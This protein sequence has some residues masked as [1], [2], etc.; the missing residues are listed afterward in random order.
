MRHWQVSRLRTNST[1]TLAR[2]SQGPLRCGWAICMLFSVLGWSGVLAAVQTVYV[3]PGGSDRNAGTAGAPFVSIQEARDYVR[4]IKADAR[5]PVEIVLEAGTYYLGETLTFGPQDSGTAESP[6][7]YRAAEPGT[8]TLSGGVKIEGDWQPYRDGIFMC[9]LDP[10]FA[11]GVDF[12]ELWVNGVRQIRARFPNGDS[13][14]PQPAGYIRTTG[15]DGW[16]HK[17]MYYEPDTFTKKTWAHPEEAVVFVFERPDFNEV[18]FWNC[19]Y[20]VRG[21]DRERR[22]VL[23]GEGGHQ[24]LL[25]HYMQAYRPGIYAHM[26]FYVEN[27]FEELDAPGE[28]YW[29]NRKGV[30]YYKPRLGQEM[31]KALVEACLFGRVLQVQ[32]SKARPV[33]LVQATV[34]DQTPALPE[35][36]KM[37]DLPV[38][39]MEE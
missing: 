8:V 39:V 27:V 7:I 19:Q 33:R 3:S 36:E 35:G 1:F 9:E 29:D 38:T 31:D 6:I 28:W 16:P 34:A 17:E 24:Q 25:Y 4:A 32:G 14:V 10:S 12:S 37:K 18:P 20:R 15:A 5:G 23:L 21:I 22:A 11:Q 30:L 13:R 26:P 2:V